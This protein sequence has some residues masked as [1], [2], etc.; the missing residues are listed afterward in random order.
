MM[1]WRWLAVAVMFIG[2]MLWLSDPRR[3][4]QYGSGIVVGVV[5]GAFIEYGL[6]SA[7][8]VWH[9]A[10]LLLPIFG[11]E[12]IW[13]C[14]VYGVQGLLFVQFLPRS[15]AILQFPYVLVCALG[16]A[17]LEQLLA[18]LHLLGLGGWRAFFVSLLV[19][20]MRLLAQLGLLSALR[21][22][23]RSNLM[24]PWEETAP[25]RRHWAQNVWFITWPSVGVAA[26]TMM[27]ITQRLVE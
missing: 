10:H 1:A 13:L 23:E 18:G 14:V 20:T 24:A 26:W 7:R 21:L 6:A 5:V 22:E 3:V 15:Y 17:G 16:T 12:A 19:H 9:D 27:K 2:G 11:R 25:W 8:P 4:R